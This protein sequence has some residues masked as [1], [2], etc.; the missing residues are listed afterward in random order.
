MMVGRHKGSAQ[1][2]LAEA[3]QGKKDRE[4]GLSIH[5]STK[6]LIHQK[7]QIKE[8]IFDLSDL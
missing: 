6:N 2:K 1:G 5:S 4:S 7:V 3:V 8:A